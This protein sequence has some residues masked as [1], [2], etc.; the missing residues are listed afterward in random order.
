MK[1]QLS[2]LGESLRDRLTR[3]LLIDGYD[4]MVLSGVLN[5]ECGQLV[6]SAR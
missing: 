3:M 6:L 2:W 5:L 4:F 1:R